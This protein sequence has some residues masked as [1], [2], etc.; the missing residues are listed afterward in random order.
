M[1][2]VVVM[3]IRYIPKK[4]KPKLVEVAFKVRSKPL[5]GF[6]IGELVK[7]E[8]AERGLYSYQ[9]YRYVIGILRK[10]K[11]LKPKTT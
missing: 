9:N 10:S 1:Y 3:K 2:F 5:D 11:A 7:K 4:V 6:V 8:L